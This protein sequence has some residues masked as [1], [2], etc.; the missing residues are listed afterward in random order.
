MSG[1][2]IPRHR[3]QPGS[4]LVLEAREDRIRYITGRMKHSGRKPWDPRD[5]GPGPTCSKKEPL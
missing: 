4:V 1:C 2:W 5:L 3:G